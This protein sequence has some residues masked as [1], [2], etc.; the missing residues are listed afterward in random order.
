MAAFRKQYPGKFH[1]EITVIKNYSDDEDS[2]ALFEDAVRRIQPDELQ[3]IPIDP[4]FRKVLGVDDATLEAVNKRL[5]GCMVL[6]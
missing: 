3:V 1:L 2:I 5:R 4:P 6:K